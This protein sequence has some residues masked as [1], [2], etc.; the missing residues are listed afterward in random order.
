MADGIFESGTFVPTLSSLSQ[1][2][3][4][5]EPTLRFFITVLLGYPIALIP[6]NFLYHAPA[7][8]QHVFYIVVGLAMSYYNFGYQT[9][10]YVITVVVN[11]LLLSLAGGTLTSIIISF[12]FNMTYFLVGTVSVSDGSHDVLWDTPHCVMVLKVMGVA[13]DLY[14][15]QKPKEQLSQEQKQYFLIRAPSLL[16][17]GGFCLFFGG[18]LAGPQFSMRR[19]INYTNN[20]LIPEWERENPSNVIPAISR[21]CFGA[22][23]VSLGLALNLA[24]PDRFFL[25]KEFVDTSI[26]YKLFVVYIWGQAYRTRYMGV[27]LFT[28]GV[29]IMS[30]LAYSGMDEMGQSKWEGS[31]NVKIY[32]L[33]TSVTFRDLVASYNTNTNKWAGRC[34]YKR[35]RFLGNRQLSQVIT[36]MFLALWHGIYPGYFHCFMGEMFCINFEEQWQMVWRKLGLSGL[37]SNPILAFLMSVFCSVFIMTSF[38]YSLVSFQLAHFSLF[39]QVYASM[40]YVGHVWFIGWALLFPFLIKPLLG[41]EKSA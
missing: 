8:I 11:Y 34:I 23:Y 28:E 27:W 12:I 6:R 17:M 40:Y 41:K 21:F 15:G 29:C 19:Y 39:S 4:V 13:Y 16:E 25:S 2:L 26:F 1:L 18:F 5:T 31:T 33:E 10:H 36:L 24:Y 20:N 37:W 3:G 35:C 14:D 30:G 32:N 9:I 38:A 7:N 22:F